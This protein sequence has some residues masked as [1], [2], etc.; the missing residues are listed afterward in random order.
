[1]STGTLSLRVWEVM[2]RDVLAVEDRES[3]TK[4]AETLR[5]NR[6]A[7]MPVI[8]AHMQVVGLIESARLRRLHNRTVGD[9][10]TSSLG[11]IDEGRPVAEAA[12]LLLQRRMPTI[13][14]VS[15]G[16]LVGRLSRN[17]LVSFLCRHQWV[18]ETCGG[19]VRGVLPPSVCSECGGT[20]SAF[21][22]EECAPGL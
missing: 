3:A 13:A 12:D 21:R 17:G 19:P 1:M 8:N 22:L 5:L 14:V 11:T 9:V 2:S 15:H 20:E 6:V 4:A 10:M 16:K 18:C 7:A